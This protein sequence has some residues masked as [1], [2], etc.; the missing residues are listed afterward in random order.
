MSFEKWR[1]KQEND[2]ETR[3]PRLGRVVLLFLRVYEK[4]GHVSREELKYHKDDYPQ[5]VQL[6]EDVLDQRREKEK[7]AE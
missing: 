5:V 4:S 1:A 3:F 7:E 2:D 6:L